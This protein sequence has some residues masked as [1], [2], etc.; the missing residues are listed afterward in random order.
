MDKV[1][2]YALPVMCI[3][4]FVGRTRATEKERGITKT[5]YTIGISWNGTKHWIKLKQQIA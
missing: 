3:R 2:T 5:N 1:D 4:W